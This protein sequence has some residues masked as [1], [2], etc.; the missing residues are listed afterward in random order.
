MES[1]L[2]ENFISM[3]DKSIY[4]LVSI[5]LPTYNGGEGLRRMLDS[6]MAQGYPN[7]EIIIS[8]NCS[9]DNTAEIVA[10]F[11]KKQPGVQYHKQK[12]N[13]GIYHNTFYVLKQA[14]GKYFMW[15]AD[16]DTFEKGAL[17]N[18]VDFLEKHP[19]FA[20]AAGQLRYFRRAAG[21]ED[22]FAHDE[23]NFN[24]TSDNPY[25]RVAQYYSRIRWV[26]MF[27]GLMRRELAQR[28]AFVPK[29]W[30]YDYHFIAS[31]AFLGKF[32]VLEDFKFYNKY[33]GGSSGNWLKFARSLDEP[34]W[35][36]RLPHVKIAVDAYKMINQH[37]I[38]NKLSRLHRILLGFLTV[39]VILYRGYPK[40]YCRVGWQKLKKFFTGS[41][42]RLEEQ[43][44]K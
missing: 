21:A 13:I 31:L 36:A 38:F 2:E 14:T 17:F 30:G 42:S 4:P 18:I 6:V 25:K 27:H 41:E 15:T 5:G 9:T 20:N 37:E 34:D 43:M 33:L 35:V 11:A 32:A 24:L 12:E 1:I 44:V 26:G 23:N 22:E 10:E 39:S 19:D 40:R 28:A 8:D 7:L 29:V 3:K 16:D